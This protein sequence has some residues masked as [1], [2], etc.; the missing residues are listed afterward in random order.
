LPATEVAVLEL[1]HNRLSKAAAGLLC[2]VSSAM[3]LYPWRVDLIRF[4][5][6]HTPKPNLVI[7][8]LAHI[9][10]LLQSGSFPHLH[11]SSPFLAHSDKLL[12]LW[13]TY[14]G[15]ME[16]RKQ[17]DSHWHTL[18]WSDSKFLFWSTEA[19][20]D[21]PKRY[22]LSCTAITPYRRWSQRR[23]TSKVGKRKHP[24]EPTAT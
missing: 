1:I 21:G 17:S 23:S 11:L 20:S 9:A 19:L 18:G 5:I 4:G 15:Q 12:Q 22:G 3:P 6:G 2:Q 24:S 10:F 14:V 16:T 13:Q 8:F 7:Q